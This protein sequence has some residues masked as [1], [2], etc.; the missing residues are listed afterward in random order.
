MRKRLLPVLLCL[1]VFGLFYACFVMN[2]RDLS[3]YKK[4]RVG[5]SA[6]DV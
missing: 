2:S 5:M 3:N 4:V 1:T 6:D